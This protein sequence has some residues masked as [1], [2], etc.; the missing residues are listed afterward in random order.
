MQGPTGERITS[1]S[2]ACA[3]PSEDL[4]D[5]GAHCLHIVDT[6]EMAFL[7]AERFARSSGALPVF[8]GSSMSP[9]AVIP[10]LDF[11]HL[12]AGFDRAA[13]DAELLTLSA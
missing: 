13:M 7:S 9:P 12:L 11:I 1:V 8:A 3:H 2:A 10:K 6:M 4:A 5:T